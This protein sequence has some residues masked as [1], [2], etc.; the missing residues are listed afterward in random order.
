ALSDLSVR[1]P[2]ERVLRFAQAP[3]SRAC[4][5]SL[6]GCPWLAGS[7]RARG[8]GRDN[9]R[10]VDDPHARGDGPGRETKARANGRPGAATPLELTWALVALLQDHRS[11][12]R[13]IVELGGRGWL[14]TFGVLEGG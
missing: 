1:P 14:K 9:M 3:L 12:L 7:S 8:R 2:P 13:V 10:D 11:V 6:V 5:G 4:A